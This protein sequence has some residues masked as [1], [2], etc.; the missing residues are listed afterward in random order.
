MLEQPE[1]NPPLRE[2]IGSHKYA[3]GSTNR[4]VTGDSQLVMESPLEKEKVA[5]KA[6]MVCIA[7]PYS[8]CYC[9]NFSQIS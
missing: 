8:I 9:S 2:A 6:Q 4:P 5:R 3:K 1:Q 7:R